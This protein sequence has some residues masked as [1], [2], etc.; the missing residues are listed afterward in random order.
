M[1][2]YAAGFRMPN[3]SKLWYGQGEDDEVDSGNDG[4][5]LIQVEWANYILNGLVR[6]IISYKNDIATIHFS[7]NFV[8][9]WILY[10]KDSGVIIMDRS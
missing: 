8:T 10:R 4:S 6:N 1:R 7:N 5:I 9:D 3:L 2:E